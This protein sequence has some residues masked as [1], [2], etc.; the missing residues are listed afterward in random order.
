MFVEWLPSL[1]PSAPSTP[2]VPPPLAMQPRVVGGAATVAVEA[3][4]GTVISLAVPPLP[5]P[6]GA[7]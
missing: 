1:N 3:K 4:R 5:S 2:A 7:L 6:V